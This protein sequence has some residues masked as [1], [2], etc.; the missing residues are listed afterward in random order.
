[1]LDATIENFEDCLQ[2]PR[3]ADESTTPAQKRPVKIPQWKYKDFV[4]MPWEANIAEI[5][6]PKTYKEPISGEDSEKWV[7]AIAK[8]LQSHEENQTWGVVRRPKGQRLLDF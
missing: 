4:N 8:E 1:M 6:E 2:S 3:P 5:A 7:Q